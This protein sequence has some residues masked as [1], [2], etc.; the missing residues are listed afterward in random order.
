MLVVGAGQMGRGIAQVCL[1][2]DCRVALADTQPGSLARARDELMTGAS[3]VASRLRTVNWPSAEPLQARIA[4]EAGPEDFAIKAEI[5]CELDRLL[6]EEAWLA[7]NTSSISITALAANVRAPERVLGLHFMNPVPKMRLVEIIRGLQTSDAAI[8][9]GRALTDKLAKVS[10]LTKDAPAFLVN[11]ML[12]PLVLEAFFLLEQGQATP[13][14]IDT[15]VKLGL[16]HPMGPLTLADFVGLDTLLAISEVLMRDLGDD[17]YRA[18]V[19]L[20]HYVS[21]GW[22]GR[23]AGRGVYRYDAQGKQ[24]RT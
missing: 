24:V 21:A 11:R 1:E 3:S 17:K 15:A 6:G 19:L 20:R 16:N 7:S 9:A 18:P 2:A 4:I 12:V 23:K 14:D 22:L 13:E 5:F 8:A 10:V